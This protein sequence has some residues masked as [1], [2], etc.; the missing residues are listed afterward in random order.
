MPGL[1]GK[2][3]PTHSVGRSEINSRSP[4]FTMAG[5][6]ITMS[7]EL[8]SSSLGVLRKYRRTAFEKFICY[9]KSWKNREISATLEPVFGL[10]A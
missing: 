8:R 2:G 10:N 1:L 4:S 5:E 6:Q 7:G 3:D 9:F